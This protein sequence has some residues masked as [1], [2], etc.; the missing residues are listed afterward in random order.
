[1]D[2]TPAPVARV[3]TGRVVLAWPTVRSHGG[4]LFYRIWRARATPT[5]GLDCPTSSGAPACSIAADDIGATTST[6][7]TDRPG[8][9]RWVYRV[10]AAAN[11]LDDPQFG[12]PYLA[13]RAVT[14]RVR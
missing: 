10:A 14:V 3:R 8:R 5:S 11:W 13:G 7:F 12:D 2:V 1:V 9:G 4:A 6:T